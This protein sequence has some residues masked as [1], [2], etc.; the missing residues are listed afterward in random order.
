MSIMSTNTNFRI[1][2]IQAA[3]ENFAQRKALLNELQ[4]QQ[5]KPESLV[6]TKVETLR[7]ELRAE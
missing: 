1:K 4:K 5:D 2:E 7:K 3:L 6:G